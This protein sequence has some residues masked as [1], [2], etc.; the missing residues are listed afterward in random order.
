MDDADFSYFIKQIKTKTNID[1]SLYKEAQ[2]KR[3]LTTLRSK[4][5]YETFASY[6]DALSRDA[7]LMNEFLDRMT[8]N[9]S[10]FWRN[11]NRWTAL[12]QR[13]FP[14]L[15]KETGGRLNVWS[16]ACS[17]GEEPYTIAMVLDKLGALERSSILATDLDAKVIERARQGVY[18]ERSLKEVPPAYRNAYF[19]AAGGGEFRVADKLLRAVKFKQY[20]LAKR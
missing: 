13:F 11:A 3:R 17:T 20:S 18:P 1:L 8:I 6:W 9:V 7:K 10:E 19:A 15:L 12:E 4:Y 16:A 2:M 5:G 14:E